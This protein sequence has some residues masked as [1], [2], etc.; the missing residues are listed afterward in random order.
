MANIDNLRSGQSIQNQTT[1][2]KKTNSSDNQYQKPAPSNE[3]YEDAFSL[4]EE[5][6]ALG[7]MNQKMAAEPQFDAA[8]IDAIKKAIANGSYKVNPDKLAAS[9]LRY[10]NELRDMQ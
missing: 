3:Q 7:A 6:K 9:I 4:S 5:S 1:Q 8:K 2:T 10:E